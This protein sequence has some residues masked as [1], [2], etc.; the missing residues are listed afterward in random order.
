MLWGKNMNAGELTATVTA[1][2][3]AIAS[4]LTAD[5]AI[6]LATVLVQLSDTLITIA[7]WRQSCEGEE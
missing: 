2:A 7:T 4:I 1:I 3:N 5:E 6:L